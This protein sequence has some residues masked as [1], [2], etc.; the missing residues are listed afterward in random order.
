MFVSSVPA[1]T[2]PQLVELGTS[3]PCEV[4]TGEDGSMPDLSSG[5]TLGSLSSCGRRSAKAIFMEIKDTT[6][7]WYLAEGV[8]L[9]PLIPNSLSTR[10]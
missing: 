2:S 7:Y 6:H 8:A 9:K 1:P 4:R 5:G 10:Q 3:V